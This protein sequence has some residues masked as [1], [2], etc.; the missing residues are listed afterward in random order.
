MVEALL[1]AILF[2][3]LFGRRRSLRLLARL[4]G[5]G[6]LAA[7]AG[8]IAIGVA[9]LR[10]DGDRMLEA[11]LWTFGATWVALLAFQVVISTIEWIIGEDVRFAI[12]RTLGATEGEL[13]AKRLREARVNRARS[14]KEIVAIAREEVDDSPHERSDDDG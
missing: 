9:K 13:A 2:V 14:F 3:L 1:A 12:L 7:I 5:S 8:A 10:H 4:L 6:A 11:G